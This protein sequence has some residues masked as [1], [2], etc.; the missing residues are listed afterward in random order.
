MLWSYSSVAGFWGIDITLGGRDKRQDE[1]AISFS[2][3]QL[4]LSQQN[5]CY[6]L[7]LLVF[8]MLN[9]LSSKLILGTLTLILLVVVEM[10]LAP[11]FSSPKVVAQ[12]SD[13]RQT[14]CY[15]Y[16]KSAYPTPDLPDESDLGLN[17]TRSMQ[18]LSQS[19]ELKRNT[20]R[21]LFYGQS[22]TNSFKR[23][24]TCSA[25]WKEIKADLESRF[26]HANIVTRNLAIGDFS[27]EK[28][29]LTTERDI[30]SFY[31][32]LIIFHVFGDHRKHEQIIRKMRSLTTADIALQTDHLREGVKPEEPDGDW[33]DFKN[34]V[35]LPKMAKKYQAELIDIRS[36]WRQYLLDNN[37][38]SQALLIDDAHLNDQGGFLMAELI[39][40]HLIVNPN[41]K[42]SF[43]D[44]VRT[45]KV[46][47]DLTYRN[48]KLTLEFVGNKLDAISN[49]FGDARAE[50]L[51][52]GKHPSELP[53]LYTFTRPNYTPDLDWPWQSNAPIRIGL[54]ENPVVEDWKIT[55]LDVESQGLDIPSFT[56][57]V[58][59]EKTGMDGV[60][61][62]N[63]N[64]ISDSKRIE[65][66]AKDWWLNL[67]PDEVLPI[68]PGDEVHF[69]SLLL[70]TDIY[71]KPE[72]R[73]P[74]LES[75]V[76]LAQGLR[77]KRHTLEIIPLEPGNVPIEA[78]RVYTPPLSE[79]NLLF[80][81]LTLTNKHLALFSIVIGSC[82]I[83]VLAF[84]LKTSFWKVLFRS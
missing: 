66:L 13:A 41:A 36:N 45:Y 69:R 30:L 76:T 40:R 84:A 80:T 34:N 8:N 74:G 75:T 46:G 21:V 68:E 61:H 15:T 81:A 54:K 60:G 1:F 6:Q 78:I 77:N 62:S 52:D 3:S 35:F 26:P 19:T 31:P 82:A 53:E 16:G 9:K 58:T 65:I 22:I 51:I 56:F 38:D 29:L 71:E 49:S 27:A 33:L 79:T 20:V 59:G 25:W 83:I 14:N 63:E 5:K 44:R 39:K 64:F 10:P 43:P 11:I 32:D 7:F 4:R 73:G 42:D 37:Y 55:V 67:E 24:F 50:I 48:G 23:R 2:L 57:A 17:L 70:G 18:L 72:P 28:L 12:G 47:Q